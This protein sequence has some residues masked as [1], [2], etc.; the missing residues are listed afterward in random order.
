MNEKMA[1]EAIER[2]MTLLMSQ[3]SWS[4]DD[5]GDDR[6][7]FR[8]DGVGRASRTYED[9][10]TAANQGVDVS[11]KL[12]RSYHLRR[13]VHRMEGRA[14]NHL[15]TRGDGHTINAIFKAFADHRQ[16]STF[17]HTDQAL[18]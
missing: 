15:A 18:G 1:N 16:L 11:R 12:R 10:G 6:L 5:R 3:Y 2:M 7:E 4:D 9:I 14:S 17:P 13:R 8:R